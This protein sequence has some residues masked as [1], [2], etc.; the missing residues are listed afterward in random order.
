MFLYTDKNKRRSNPHLGQ[1]KQLL[2]KILVFQ[3]LVGAIGW[4]KPKID[5]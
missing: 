5:A 1:R 3:S 2:E 4:H